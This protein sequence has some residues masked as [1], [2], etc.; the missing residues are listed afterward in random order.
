MKS[1]A[2]LAPFAVHSLGASPFCKM[3]AMDRILR[4]VTYDYGC[5]TWGGAL[6]NTGYGLVSVNGVRRLVHR[7]VYESEIGAI[8]DGMHIDHLCRNTR[9][10]NP[11]HLEAVTARENN[12]RGA[13]AGALARRY[14][15][16]TH[17]KRGHLLSGENLVPDQL[18][19]NGKTR[20]RCKIC[21]RITARR[22]YVDD[23]NRSAAQ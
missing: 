13:S 3:T 8:P 18:L 17:C 10:C 7:V 6:I 4:R 11:I 12:A 23:K 5:W 2:E 19:R 22:R 14:L 1:F 21:E 15:D 20:R 9:C 16:Q